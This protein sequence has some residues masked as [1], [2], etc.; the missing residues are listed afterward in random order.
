[1]II[2]NEMTVSMNPESEQNFEVP[3]RSGVGD[4]DVSKG[5]YNRE[6]F[7]R[8]LPFRV[9]F[10]DSQNWRT[11]TVDELPFALQWLDSPDWAR[12]RLEVD[13]YDV[14]DETY[15]LLLSEWDTP[16]AIAS[17]RLSRI[18][19]VEESLSWSMFNGAGD[20][21]KAQAQ[22][23]D[24]GRTM[25][26]L[27]EIAK[28]GKLWDLTRFATPVDR[29]VEPDRLVGGMLEL[30]AVGYGMMR[31]EIPEEVKEQRDD[32]RWIFN[33]TKLLVMALEHTG[34][35]FDVIAKGKI[36]RDDQG[37]SYF[38]VVKP[39]EGLRYLRTHADEFEF[40]NKHVTNGLLKANAL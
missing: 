7:E 3:A 1:M 22:R 20:W 8:V 5:P 9:K 34:I 37:K 13:Q 24:D 15:N 33:G 23:H 14:M 35:Q 38:C 17:L 16:E 18:G 27:N 32:I 40:S 10:V 29:A 25:E 21:M 30:F 4:V 2:S 39:E 11:N 28:D 26:Y 36:N 31:N 19:S 12:E 6:V